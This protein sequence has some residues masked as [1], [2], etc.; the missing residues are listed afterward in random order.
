MIK[1]EEVRKSTI[2]NDI[3]DA[4]IEEALAKWDTEM[5]FET[6]RNNNKPLKKKK[7]DD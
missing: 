5:P 6:E 7:D 3:Y 1:L 2:E 4:K